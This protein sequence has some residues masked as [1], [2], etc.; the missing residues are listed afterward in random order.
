MLDQFLSPLDSERA[1]RSL[2][3]LAGHNLSGLALTGG[4]AVEI[5]CVRAGREVPKRKL[6]DIDFI[7]DSFDDIP[8]TLSRDYLFRHIHPS[9]PPGKTLLQCVDSKAALR[10]DVFRSSGGTMQR[11]KVVDLVAAQ[12]M[13]IS[14]A[15]RFGSAMREIG[16]RPGGWRSGLFQVCERFLSAR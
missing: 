16:A 2:E 4:F 1:L 8:A 9:D 6:N 3:T 13:R 12:P 15:R 14:R 7:V 11:T 5:Y 10:I